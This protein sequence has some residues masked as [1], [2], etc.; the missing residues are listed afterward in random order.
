MGLGSRRRPECWVLPRVCVEAGGCCISS[1]VRQR[2]SGLQDIPAGGLWGQRAGGMTGPVPEMRGAER[3][4]LK[5]NQ[6]SGVATSGLTISHLSG[7][8]LSR[9]RRD[10]RE[11]LVWV[12]SEALGPD[13]GPLGTFRQ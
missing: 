5:G 3:V 13:E 4:V 9:R 12:G 6:E 1:A 11:R 10:C 2:P 8:S 7:E